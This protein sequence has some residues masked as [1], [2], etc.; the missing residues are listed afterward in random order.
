MTDWFGGEDATAS[1]NAGNDLLEPGTKNQWD[2]LKKSAK[3]GDLPKENID[4]SAKRILKLI[5]GSKK[6]KVTYLIIIQN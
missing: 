1:I 4:T 6:W 2:A 3:E 5:L